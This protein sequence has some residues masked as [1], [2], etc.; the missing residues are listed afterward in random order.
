M[1]DAGRIIEAGS[2]RQVLA[3]P[4]SPRTRDFVARYLGRNAA[5]TTL[6]ASPP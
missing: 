4:T 6:T 2:P 5:L 1:M 3:E